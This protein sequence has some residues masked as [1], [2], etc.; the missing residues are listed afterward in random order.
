MSPRPPIFVS[1]VSR[2]L[3]SA[4]QLVANTLTFLGYQPLWQ[5]IFGTEGGDLRDIL[6]VQ[7]DQCKGVVQLVGQCYGAEPPTADEQFG[8]VSYTQFEALY[9]RKRAKKVWYLFIDEQF[10]GDHCEEEPAD[11][12]ELQAAYRQRLQSDT[13][14]FHPLASSEALEASVL[15]LRDDLNRLRRGVKQWAVGVTAL[16]IVITSLI[17]WQLRGEAEMKA[18]M[19]KLRRGIMEYPQ[20]EAQ[21]RGSQTEENATALQEQL[22][23]K[24]ATQ[25]DVDPKILRERLPRFAQE[26]KRA[27]NASTY[28]RANASYVAADYP[29]AERLALEA[30]RDAQ[31]VKPPKTKHILQALELAGLSAQRGIQYARAMQHFQEA[32]KLTDPNRDLKEWATVQHDIADLLV[33]WGKYS[34]AEQLLRSV[35]EVRTASLGTEDRDTLDSRH[36]LIYPLTRQTRYDEAEAEARQ[37]LK[38]REKVLGFENVD[39]I[40]SRYLLADVLA[41]QGKY[42]EAEAL[43]RGII[44]LAEKLLG[45]EHPRTVAARLGLATVLSDEGKNVEAESLYRGVIDLDAKIY[46][47][48]DPNTLNDR[49]NLATALQAQG[50]YQD[51][52]AEY[53]EVIKL[54]TQVVG[55]EH[56]NLLTIRNNFAEMLDDERKF[57]EAEAECREIIPIEQK[58]LRPENRLTLNTRGN[59]AVALVNQEKFPEAEIQCRD[60]LGLMERV[61]GLDHPDTQHFTTKLATGLSRQ[62]RTEAAIEI[63]QGA[64]ERARQALGPENG[65]TKTY[66]QLAQEL[67]AKH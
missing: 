21:V 40:V 10:P 1:A 5:D 23:L 58:V 17:I 64:A 41:D 18:E 11:L 54:E 59:L 66:T 63:A 53:R 25:L 14:L 32:E 57:A 9:A 2:E 8:R 12:R 49:G 15:K 35:I 60:V 44:P 42:V 13:H 27:P 6:R 65:L 36:R 67:A 61:L 20:L 38:V 47:P 52:E 28:E 50:K 29:G 43:Y 51:A 33:A 7:I 56:P 45:R 30:A 19:V 31:K 39:T 48:R 62:N 24:L 37:V 4:R 16:L 3:H 22:Y 34:E 26:L 55:S 46:G